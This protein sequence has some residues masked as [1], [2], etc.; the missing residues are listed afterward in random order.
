MRSHEVCVLG[1]GPSMIPIKGLHDVAWRAVAWRG[2]AEREVM[3]LD[4][5]GLM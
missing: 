2:V 5:V 3:R 4:S 1:N